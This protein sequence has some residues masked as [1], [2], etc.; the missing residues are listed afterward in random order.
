LFYFYLSE[1]KA[2]TQK[3]LKAQ[4]IHKVYKEDGGTLHV[5]K[6]VDM[7]VAEGEIVTILGASGAGKSTLLHILGLLD[8]PTQGHVYFRGQ[9]LQSLSPAQKAL[10][11]NKNFG[12]VFQFYHLL[13]EL[14]AM[15]NVLLPSMVMNSTLGWCKRRN[16]LK[17]RAEKIIRSVDLW[18]RRK[19]KPKALSG[20]E[21]QRI[22]IA[23]ALMNEPDILFCDE[24][25]GNL[26]S[27]TS[28]EVVTL[29]W[30]INKETGMAF[31]IVTH[32][33]NLARKSG[34]VLQMVDGRLVKVTE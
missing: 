9:D 2:M 18:P 27:K 4:N 34:R 17:E 28:D 11:R 29:L 33:P 6:G 7:E 32:N 31:V 3:L 15:E 20:G 30:N 1:E 13:P 24:P 23:R 10:V 16:E 14:D 8:T 12:F 25:T 26:D 22:A 5:L 19:H 21:K